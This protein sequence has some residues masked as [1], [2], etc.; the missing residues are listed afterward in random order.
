M[1]R[2]WMYKARRNDAYFCGELDKFIQAV[3]NHARNEKTHMI[4][5]LCKTCKNVEVFSDITTIRLHVLVG[6]FVKNYIIWTYHGEKALPPTENTPDEI[7]EDAK[8][9]RLFD[10]YDDFFVHVVNDDGDGVGEGPIDGGSDNGSD[11]ELDDGN[12]LSQLLRHTK[13]ELLVGTTKGFANFKTVK[14][15]VEENIYE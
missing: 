8:Y 2:T 5:C 9:D 1:D 4:P 10:T 3:E 12:F 15:S 11:D 6:G 13:A 14:K 7:V